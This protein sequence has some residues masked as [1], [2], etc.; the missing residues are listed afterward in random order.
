[1]FKVPDSLVP[2]DETLSAAASCLREQQ[3]PGARVD[4]SPVPGIGTGEDGLVAILA[5]IRLASLAGS[6]HPI[7]QQ[8]G[9]SGKQKPKKGPLG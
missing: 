7:K 5:F 9:F 4:R 3:K 8:K 2:Y 6:A 1:M